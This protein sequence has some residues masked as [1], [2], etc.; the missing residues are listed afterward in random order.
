MNDAIAGYQCPPRGKLGF[1]S[2]AV[3]WF[4]MVSV[5]FSDSVKASMY[6]SGDMKLYDHPNDC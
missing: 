1:V 5:A 6:D 3:G 4:I 2:S